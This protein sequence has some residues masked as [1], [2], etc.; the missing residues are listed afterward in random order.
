MVLF[1]ELRQSV[2][3]IWDSWWDLYERLIAPGVTANILMGSITILIALLL[4]G[5]GYLAIAPLIPQEGI[6]LR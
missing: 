6:V 3:V 4:L 1:K 5:I 2:R